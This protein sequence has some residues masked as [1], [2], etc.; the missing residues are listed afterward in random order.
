MPCEDQEELDLTLPDKNLASEEEKAKQE[1]DVSSAQSSK[2]RFLDYFSSDLDY[3]FDKKAV[4]KP[5]KESSIS[6]ESES[7]AEVISR[8]SISEQIIRESD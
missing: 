6:S 4:V 5:H 3:F 7:V 2:I 8:L 1:D